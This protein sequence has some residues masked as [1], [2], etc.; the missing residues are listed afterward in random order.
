VGIVSQTAGRTREHTYSP[1]G[2]W[3]WDGQT[4][5]PV[6]ATA[7]RGSGTGPRWLLAALIAVVV[8]VT[9]PLGVTE[10]VI[11]S[12][13]GHISPPA[14]L[15][16]SPPSMPTLADASGTGIELA[17]TSH[18][19]RCGSPQAVGGFFGHPPR[20]RQCL[21]GSE[22]Q[23][24]TVMTIGSDD[25]HVSVVTVHVAELRPGG[26]ESA[27]L[28]LFQAVASAAVAG[29]D[30]PAD[31]AW[32]SAHFDQAGTSMT[33]V[34]GVTLRLMVSGSQRTLVVE[35]TPGPS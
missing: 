31:S 18:G 1:D 29:P 4:W 26:D 23:L 17:A 27:A 13:I 11:A 16:A 28:A 3:W 22:T 12:R 19:L 7:S 9:V 5:Q 24:I 25:S 14:G 32:L 35:P 21:R 8:T 15:P 20:I 10:V 34:D 6:P 2:R 33:T 30:G